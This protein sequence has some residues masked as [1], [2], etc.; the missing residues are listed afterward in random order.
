[1]DW[2]FIPFSLDL[3]INHPCLFFNI[4]II[5]TIDEKLASMKGNSHIYWSI[6]VNK[7]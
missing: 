3:I 6:L 7:E 5:S 4:S 1:M 2:M